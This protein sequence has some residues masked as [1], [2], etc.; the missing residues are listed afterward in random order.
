MSHKEKKTNSDHKSPMAKYRRQGREIAMQSL[1]QVE[2]GHLLP[3][4]AAELS[5]LER[6]AADNAKTFARMLIQGTLDHK[7]QID[8]LIRSYSQHWQFDRI[9]RID[10][11]ILRFSIYSLLYLPEIPPIVTI[12]EAIEI[13]KQ[14][15]SEDAWR[16]T[17]G[18]L[19]AIFIQEIKNDTNVSH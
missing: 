10:L 12:D 1:Y 3:E 7:D 19:D 4:E 15:S 9:P 17:N 2:W 13:S 11:A 5:W 14:Y 8:D 18:M 6:P 16:Y